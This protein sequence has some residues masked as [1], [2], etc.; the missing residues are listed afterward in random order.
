MANQYLNKTG[1]SRLVYK[2]KT[3]IQ[4]MS[5]EAYLVWG[6]K[7]VAGDVS[8]VD[9]AA[10]D[11]TNANRLAFHPADCIDVE[12][13]TDGGSTWLDYEATDVNKTTLVTTSHNFY[14]GK[15]SASKATI[16]DKLRITLTAKANQHYWHCQKLLMWISTSG[17]NDCKVLVETRHINET[18]FSQYGEYKLLGWGGWNSIPFSAYFSAQTNTGHV[19]KIRLTFTAGSVSGDYNSNLSIGKL[20]MIAPTC[21]LNANGE[22]GLNGRIYSLS[23][24][25]SVTFPNKVTATSFVGATA[26]STSSGLMSA[27]DKKNIDELPTTKISSSASSKG[28]KVSLGGTVKSPTI[29]IETTTNGVATNNSGVVSGAEVKNYVDTNAAST[30]TFKSQ[31]SSSNAVNGLV[32]A[33][34]LAN[35]QKYL[36]GDGTWQTP[37]SVINNL[38]STSTTGALSAAQGKILN[39][40]FGVGVYDLGAFY[41]YG[42]SETVP[43]NGCLIEIGEVASATMVTLQITGFAYYKHKPINSM[44]VFYDWKNNSG[45]LEIAQYGG[46]NLGYPVGNLMV[47]HY[48]GK[49]YAWIKQTSDFNTLSFK[50]YSNKNNLSPIVTNAAMHTNGVTLLTEIEPES[51][52]SASTESSDGLMESTDKKNLNTIKKW[53]DNIVGVDEDKVINKWDEIVSFLSGIPEGDTLDGLIEAVKTQVGDLKDD[54]EDGTVIAQESKTL[55]H[56]TIGSTTKPIYLTSGVATPC[57]YT[58]GTSVPSDAKFTDNNTTYSFASGTNKFTVTPSGGT[59]QEVSVTPS[60]TN[61][62]TYSGTLTSGQVAVLDGTAGKIKASGYTIAKSVPSDAVFTDTH[63]TAKNIVSNSAGAIETAAASNG[64]VHINL[65]ENGTWR[66]GIN[67][68]GSGATL[69]TSDEWGNITITSEDTNTTYVAMK[70]ATSSANG[71]EGLVPKPLYGSENAFLRGD[72]TWSNRINEFGHTGT[73]NIGTSFSNATGWFRIARA[74]Y[75]RSTPSVFRV[76]IYRNYSY[77]VP[78]AYVF[79]VCT[80]YHTYD[81]ISITQVS[82]QAS[83]IDGNKLIDKI[84]V[85]RDTSSNGSIVYFDF[86]VNLSKT[87]NQFFWYV[88]GNAFSYTKSEVVRNPTLSSTTESYEFTT[89]NG[90]K[91]NGDIYEGDSTLSEKYTTKSDI[92]SGNVTAAKATTADSANAIGGKGLSDLVQGGGSIKHIKVVTSLPASPSND[93]LYL[94]KQ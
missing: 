82:G 72:G 91:T 4:D 12:Y 11:D 28:V 76:A 35:S 20:R 16:K 5:K 14:I 25:K 83:T 6:G 69:V 7:N 86:H 55:G 24:D 39:E 70:G 40:K 80:S 2:I 90:F 56:E 51:P 43:S 45:V 49:V 52:L 37:V 46:I 58:L 88:I 67:I 87:G 75:L 8:P 22:L 79:D 48:D 78:E 33:P 42:Y 9:A 21:Y 68:V 10:C 44:F 19:H 71:E 57:T 31:T 60:I 65:V 47:Y 36:R 61:N 53:Y 29:S 18:S 92:T 89:V 59:A 17:A 85:T 50:L 73:I 93:T 62:V 23:A 38:E 94:I 74:R 77:A 26:T 54:I 34:T 27:A 66:S 81:P 13:S 84:R 15:K 3:L 63:Y 30:A 41:N 32:P 1:L 64:D